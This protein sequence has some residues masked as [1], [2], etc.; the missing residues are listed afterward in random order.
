MEKYLFVPW[1][2]WEAVEDRGICHSMVHEVE[3]SQTRLSTQQQKSVCPCLD[4]I[5]FISLIPVFRPQLFGLFNL[6]LFL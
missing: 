3:K 4:V 6:L 5:I 2:K 1:A